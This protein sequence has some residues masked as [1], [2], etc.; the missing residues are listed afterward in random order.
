MTPS[1]LAHAALRQIIITINSGGLVESSVM[2]L[3][4]VKHLAN[5]CSY[6]GG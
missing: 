5:Y 4:K 3:E 2:L 6:F 1:F